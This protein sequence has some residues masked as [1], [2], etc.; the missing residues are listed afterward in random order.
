M[1]RRPSEKNTKAEILAAFDE[2]LKEKKVLET[3]AAQATKERSPESSQKPALKVTVVQPESPTMTSVLEGLSKL[4]LSFGG[5]ISDLSEKLTLEAVKLQEVRQAIT[6]EVQQL[7][8]LHGL[9]A[10]DASLETLIEQYDTSFKTFNEELGQCRETLE[11]EFSQAKKAWAKEQEEHRRTVKERNE[12]LTK[13]RQRDTKEY[14]YNLTLQRKLD[15]DTY[16]QAQ[17]ALCQELEELQRSHDQQ[18]TER[19]MAIAEREKQFAEL[20][21][22]VEG[23]PKELESA[24]KRAKEE[25]KGIA[26]HQAKVKADLYAKDVEGNKRNYELRIQSL[27]ENLQN[28]ETRIHALSQ[29]LSAVLKQVQDLAVKAIEG[30]ANVSSFQAMREIAIEQAKTQSKNK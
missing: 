20:K 14:T 12:T 28:Q 5:A 8:T 9:R 15:T 17:K 29:Q 13:T 16:E 11:Q 23:F 6:T 25:G 27:Q 1:V 2:L 18:W 21:A 4:Q 19:E 7:E 3:Q 10:D 30:A 26:H 24:I 22:K